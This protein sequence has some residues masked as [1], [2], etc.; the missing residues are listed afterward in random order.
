MAFA[1]LILLFAADRGFSARFL[2]T[3][4][5]RCLGTLCIQPTWCTCSSSGSSSSRCWRRAAHPD[6]L[7]SVEVLRM[8]L[9]RANLLGMATLCAT[10]PAAWLSWRFVEFSAHAWSRRRASRM[11]AGREERIA[12][13]SPALGRVEKTR[14]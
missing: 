14:A 9:S 12:Q 10:I 3:R 7:G 1:A 11:G 4:P 6:Q 5:M 13:A 2:A 8:T